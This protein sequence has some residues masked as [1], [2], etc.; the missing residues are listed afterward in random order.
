MPQHCCEEM[1]TRLDHRCDRHE[2]PFDCPDAVIHH[3]AKFQ[4][5][6]L[7]I[8]DGGRST[9]GIVFCPWCGR[10]LP[11]SQRDRWF[12]E[13]ERRGIYPWEDELP[14]EFEDDRWLRPPG[15]STS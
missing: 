10:R 2:D 1:T 5:Y 9:L 15:G 7:V 11:E 3:S 4:E 8:H 12:D 6:G 14:A 13:L